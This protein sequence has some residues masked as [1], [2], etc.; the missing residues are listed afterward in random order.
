MLKTTALAL[1]SLSITPCA[2]SMDALGNKS[3]NSQSATCSPC[4]S[5]LSF[6]SNSTESSPFVIAHNVMS[7]GF[8]GTVEEFEKLSQDSSKISQTSSTTHTA[9]HQ[10]QTTHTPQQTATDGS[11]AKNPIAIT[12]H[13]IPV[14]S[15]LS[16]MKAMNITG[17]NK[18]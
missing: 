16:F 18:Q 1:L 2:L 15:I 13:Q 4:S 12:A 9:I 6:L 5:N 10:N 7:Q 14:T 11:G 8:C 3:K 17:S